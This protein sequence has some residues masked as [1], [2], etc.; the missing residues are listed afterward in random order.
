MLD[1]PKKQPKSWP[2]QEAK[3]KFSEL[4]DTVLRDGPQIVTRRGVETVAIVPFKQWRER[5]A[6]KYKNI[7]EWLLAPEPRF[8][9]EL[10]DRKAFRL[11]P[12]P[13]L[14]RPPMYLLDTNRISELRRPK[15][16]LG[17]RDWVKAQPHD[18]LFISAASI[19]EI[20]RGIVK[21]GLTDGDKAQAIEAWLEERTAQYQVLDATAAVFRIWGRLM[22]RAQHS[23]VID[24][25]IAATAINHYL[26]LA[27]R[28][29]KDFRTFGVRLLNP[30][31]ASH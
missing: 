23:Q 14:Y 13:K 20:S 7:K 31:E 1:K 25:L 10:P 9:L 27:T 5:P 30:F 28:N 24:A 29:S 18:S 22:N 21:A 3:A 17:V 2:L 15:A 4:V 12:P 16:H 26:V 8:D 6:P 19:G 11:R